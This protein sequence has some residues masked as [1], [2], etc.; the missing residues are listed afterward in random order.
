MESRLRNLLW[1]RIR[2]LF[3]PFCPRFV[4][5]PALSVTK[6][7]W[8]QCRQKVMALSHSGIRAAQP[9]PVVSCRQGVRG[10]VKQ[11]GSSAC[12]RRAPSYQ[13]EVLQAAPV[14]T[15]FGKW[16]RCLGSN[17]LNKCDCN[18]VKLTLLFGALTWQD[19]RSHCPPEPRGSSR[20]LPDQM[21]CPGCLCSW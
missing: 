6:N 2:S 17:K 15:G 10:R 16:W 3:C 9:C 19:H 20:A 13:S 18:K 21:G 1:K 8:G 4:P 12:P 11:T 7:A 5:F 14:I